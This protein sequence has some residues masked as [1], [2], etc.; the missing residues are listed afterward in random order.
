MNVDAAFGIFHLPDDEKCMVIGRSDIDGI[1][2]GSIMR[3]LGGGGHPGAGSALL[4]KVNGEVVKEML[5]ELIR[6]T[7]RHRS[8]KRFDV[9]SGLQY[10]ERYPHG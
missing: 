9:V 1:N 3:G 7:S 5:M 8:G 4:R 6:A 2:I 10:R